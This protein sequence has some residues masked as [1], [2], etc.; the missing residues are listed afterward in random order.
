MSAL[1]SG[2]LTFF[3]TYG[4]LALWICVFIAAAGAPLPIYV[5]LLAAGVFAA[6]GDFNIVLLFVIAFSA[7]FC[8]DNVGYLIGRR[9]GSKVL[10]W[11]GKARKL[12]CFIPSRNIE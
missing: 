10:D 9:W 11:R 12:N 2:L 5:V 1:L 8:G 7:Q 4:Y 3:E 6:L